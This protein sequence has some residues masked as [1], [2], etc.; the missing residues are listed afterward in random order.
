MRLIRRKISLFVIKLHFISTAKKGDHF[1][2]RTFNNGTISLLF[3]KTNITLP[4]PCD[5]GQ[6]LGSGYRC[7]SCQADYYNNNGYAT[8]CTKCP[9]NKGVAAGAGAVESDCIW[10]E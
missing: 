3:I 9:T 2:L 6:Y 8:S 7:Y 5:P 1:E 4:V 10:S